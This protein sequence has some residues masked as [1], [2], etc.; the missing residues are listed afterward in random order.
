MDINR[1]KEKYEPIDGKWYIKDVLGRGAYG[2][3]FEIERKDFSHEKS[4]LKVI[5]IPAS[6]EE[7][8][9]YR[10]E[11]YSLDDKSVTSYFYG[12]V[13]EFTR[14]FQLMS[15]LKGE[16]NIV[17]I[18]DYDVIP[19]EDEIGWDILIRME[20]LTPMAKHFKENYPTPDDVVKLG[21][22][23]CKALE[24]CE[25]QNIIHR[26]IKP[27]NIFV[28]DSG[29]YKLGDFGVAKTLEKT[30]SG[31]SK[32][33]TYTY[34][35]PEVYKGEIC[36]SN[37]DIY[38]LGIVMYK[39]LN[40]NLEPFR[41]EITHTDEEKA[42]IM[43]LSGN[44]KMPAPV[45]ASEELSK[46]VLKACAFNPAE[47]YASAQEMRKDLERIALGVPVAAPS[48]KTIDDSNEKTVGMFS[49]IEQPEEKT[50]GMFSDMRDEGTVGLFGSAP[51]PAPKPAPASSERRTHA[52]DISDVKFGS[53]FDS[54][55]P[56]K[57]V[58]NKGNSKTGL[59]IGIV[60]AVAVVLI[61]LIVG[62]GLMMSSG[63]NDE[64]AANN[65]EPALNKDYNQNNGY[66]D[67]SS[68]ANIQPGNGNL[69]SSQL[70]QRQKAYG[71]F[72]FGMS[73]E[74]VIN[75]LSSVPEEEYGQLIVSYPKPYD[76]DTSIT[77]DAKPER[78]TFTFMGENNGLSGIGFNYRNTNSNS[79]LSSEASLHIDDPVAEKSINR[80]ISH[81]G[82]NYSYINAEYYYEYIWDT[83]FGAVRV[84]EFFDGSFMLE[85]VSS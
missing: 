15:K 54:D 24:I 65:D 45:N 72:Y 16:S 73:K 32:K 61:A 2:T 14:E 29:N 28:S 36:K 44:E 42:F 51:A 34:M 69:S 3:V 75:L 37:I 83:S 18:E 7:V 22:D 13:E 9:S 77:G 82:N 55:E 49:N 78:L 76:L 33:G 12:F 58:K 50:V 26:D 67:I 25:K 66:S 38:S 84:Y 5:T 30:S 35:A 8:K 64:P 85:I 39:L 52:K 63:N 41:T 21:I 80:I 70:P 59:I 6:P 79:S 4:A 48:V 20:L 74:E 40:N 23:I 62:V 81:F 46:I 47:R 1:I 10:E 11:N 68:G 53:G 19:H 31:L 17:S 60:C 57:I 71:K 43:R 27:S 56:Q